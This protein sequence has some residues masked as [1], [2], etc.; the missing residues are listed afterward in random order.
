MNN[1]DKAAQIIRDSSEVDGETLGYA[2]SHNIAN[3][4]ADAG[5]IAPDLPQ[6]YVYAGGLLEWDT[7]RGYVHLN[8]GEIEVA[9][10]H[11]A[12]PSL[13][14]NTLRVSDREAAKALVL[15]LVA[16]TNYSESQLS[17]TSN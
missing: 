6:P 5:L 11:P 3:D 16:A 10:D 7:P 13:E 14:Y 1:I 4:L 17:A 8:N 9:Y 15:A 2:H 12:A